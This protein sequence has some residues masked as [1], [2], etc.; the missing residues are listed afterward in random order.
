[1]LSCANSAEAYTASRHAF[2][3]RFISAVS[4]AIAR[5]SRSAAVMSA[6]CAATVPLTTNTAIATHAALFTVLNVPTIARLSG[7]VF[8]ESPLSI[9]QPESGR[10]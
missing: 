3:C 10:N 6:L 2:S 1:M 9:L 5:P 7:S 8:L 4:F